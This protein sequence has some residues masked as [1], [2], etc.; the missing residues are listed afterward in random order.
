VAV[1]PAEGVPVAE[2][3]L[4]AVSGV[5]AST[6]VEDDARGVA[7]GTAEAGLGVGG[8]VGPLASVT[9]AACTVPAA[10]AAGGSG[11]T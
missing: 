2:L 9:G 4:L 3:L 11:L 6:G 1:D 7:A 10:P 8:T 5:A